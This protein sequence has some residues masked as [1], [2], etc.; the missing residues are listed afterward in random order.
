MCAL[1]QLRKPDPTFEKK[2]KT[3]GY[4]GATAARALVASFPLTSVG[5]GLF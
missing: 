3:A 5:V 2:E 1:G 4:I